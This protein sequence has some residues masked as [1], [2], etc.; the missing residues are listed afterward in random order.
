MSITAKGEDK[1]PKKDDYEKG[2]LKL[3][4]EIAGKPVGQVIRG[5]GAVG[6]AGR[7]L[8]SLVRAVLPV[9]VR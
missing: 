5:P 6:R 3:L 8:G 1:D 7:A 2:I 9:L 4:K